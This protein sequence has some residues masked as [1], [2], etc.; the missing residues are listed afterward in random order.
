MSEM[1]GHSPSPGRRDREPHAPSVVRWI[2]FEPFWHVRSDL[3]RALLAAGWSLETGEDDV[4]VFANG[5]WRVFAFGPSEERP[6]NQIYATWFTTEERRRD[7]SNRFDYGPLEVY[8]LYS[9]VML[10]SLL[11]VMDP[12]IAAGIDS[13][14][15]RSS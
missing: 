9:L 14:L 10:H 2:D 7:S 4:E 3:R 6:F 5:R 11:R 15:W 1:N 13:Y 8:V 12:D